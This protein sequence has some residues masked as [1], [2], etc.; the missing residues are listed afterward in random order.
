M[1]KNSQ[2]AEPLYEICMKYFFDELFLNIKCL[3]LYI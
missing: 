1:G 2:R 3:L